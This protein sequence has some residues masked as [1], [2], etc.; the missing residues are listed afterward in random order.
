[1]TEADELDGLV[2]LVDRCVAQ[3]LP[4]SEAEPIEL[5]RTHM[6]DTG[7]GRSDLALLP[8]SPSR[9]SGVLRHQPA[10]TVAVIHKLTVEWGIP[11]D[12]LVRP[13]RLRPREPTF[14]Q[15]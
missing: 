1:M 2:D 15:V 11:A 3:G 8:G 13:M 6:A 5:I 10:Q 14:G 7:R 12:C 9:A 4:F